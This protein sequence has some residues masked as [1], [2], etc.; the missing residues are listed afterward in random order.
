MLRSCQY[1]GRIHDREYICHQRQQKILQRQKKRTETN[2]KIYD[3]RRSETWKEKSREIKQ[4]DRY[5]CQICIH[6]MYEPDRKYETRDLSVHHIIP[7][8]EDWDR[9]LDT[10]ILITLCR[11]H[12]EMA[13]VG[14]IP[15][16]ELLKIVEEQEKGQEFTAIG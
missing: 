9:R 1:C 12:H 10:D 5:C 6:G 14:N 13:E 16:D 15:R 2:K 11:R 4:R 3:F 8:A 7:I